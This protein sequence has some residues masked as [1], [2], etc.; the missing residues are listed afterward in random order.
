[1]HEI[2]RC[3][4]LEGCHFNDHTIDFPGPTKQKETATAYLKAICEYSNGT[5]YEFHDKSDSAQYTRLRF[6]TGTVRIQNSVLPLDSLT[7]NFHFYS[8]HNSAAHRIQGAWGNGI[9]G[10]LLKKNIRNTNAVCQVANCPTCVPV[11]GGGG[12]QTARPTKLE[13]ACW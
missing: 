5:N 11:G 8:G 4:I 7:I 1:L 10:G 9:S 12:V 13:L 6:E 2:T 3:H